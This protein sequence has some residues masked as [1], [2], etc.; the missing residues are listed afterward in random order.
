MNREFTDED[1]DKPVYTH[2]G[3][4]VGTVRDVND[5]RAFVKR[6]PDRTLTEKVRDLLGW[7]SVEENE[8]RSE[9]VDSWDDDEIR[10]REP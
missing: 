10:L 7:D 2:E 3:A 8:L 6:D 1:R 4:R 5:G 9:Q